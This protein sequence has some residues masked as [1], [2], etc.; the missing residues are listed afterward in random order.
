MIRFI[1]LLLS[2]LALSMTASAQTSDPAPTLPNGI[3]SGDINQTSAV[4]WARSTATGQVT[5]TVIGEDGF[6]AAF[7]AEVTDPMLPLRVPVDGLT[8]ATTYN[9]TVTDAAGSILEGRFRT[10][11]A[12][13]S[14]NGLRFGITGDWRGELAPYPALGNVTERALEFFVL[15]GD[16]IYADYPS[17]AVPRMQARTLEEFRLKHDEVYSERYGQNSWAEVRAST[18][19]YVTIDD[20]EVM[21]DFSGGASPGIDRRFRGES[22]EYINDTTL[23]EIGLQAFQEYNPLQEEFYGETGDTRTSGERKL[24]RYRT[25][26]LDAALFIT[27]ARSFRDA[28]IPQVTSLDD[29]VVNGFITA[30]FDPNRTLLGRAQVDALKTD[31]L[32]AHTV[33]IT[34]KFVLVAEPVQNLGV[35]GGEDRYEG[36]AAE[37]TELLQ[38]IDEHDIS[39][40][41]FVAADIHGTLVNNLTYQT[42]PGGEQIAVP[43][44]EI[45]TGSVAFDAPFGPSVVGL[46]RD[47]GLISPQ[48]FGLYSLL[49]LAAKEALITQVIDSQLE[50]LGY[51]TI[52]L[53]GAPLDVELVEGL[54]SAT[55]TYGWT[56]FEIDANT[57]ALT[58]TTYGVPWYTAAM[59]A[60]EDDRTALLATEPRIMSQ[61]VVQAQD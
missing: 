24:Y 46:A 49:P 4:L 14:H 52:G 33:G 8:P 34:W 11:A 45:T 12:P 10:A 57:Q 43:V 47:I 42:E 55:N 30:A 36:Y 2:M 28:P 16:T 56:E 15:Q 35:V 18:G 26:G 27:E 60:D 40:V 39:N 37:R 20:H 6:S 19:V 22:V 38:F 9:Y 44:F 21:N 3:A 31:L 53:D 32:E 5:F 23:Y 17:P 59:M 29:G 48:Q 25:F 50:N 58:V 51:D 41:V 54:Y 13:E 61:F 1:S 7:S